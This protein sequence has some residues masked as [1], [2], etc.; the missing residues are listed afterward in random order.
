MFDS[1]AHAVSIYLKH[2]RGGNFSGTR[3]V[4][5]MFFSPLI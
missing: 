2:N 4:I 1:P 5:Q 3:N